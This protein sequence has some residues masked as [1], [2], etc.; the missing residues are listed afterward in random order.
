MTQAA[1]QKAFQKL[2]WKW[3]IYLVTI[4][5][6]TLWLSST[7]PGLLGKADAIGYAVCHRIDARSFHLGDRQLPL[8]VRCSGM[9]LG[10]MLGLTYQGLLSRRMSGTP[11]KRVLAV[12]AVL[13]ATFAID[14]LNSYLH[15]EPMLQMFPGLPRLYEPNHLLRLLTGTGMGLVIAAAI[16]PAF[17]QTVWID[18]KPLPAL[19]GLRSL[20]GLLILAGLLDAL[21]MTESSLILYPLALISAAG[22]VAILTMVYTMIWL[23]IVGREN[24]HHSVLQMTLPLVGGFIITLSQ[25]FFIGFVRFLLTGTWG[26]F[27]I[28]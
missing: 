5:L 9:Y 15:L 14:G 1:L 27:P 2:P 28:G 6:L 18:H 12:L 11:P 8:C 22:V 16:F 23:M 17:N 25:I 26:G 21:V 3:G 24:L 20:G 7:P 19:N 4:L 10:A 13:T